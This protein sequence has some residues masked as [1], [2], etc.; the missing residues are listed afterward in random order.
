[1]LCELSFDDGCE[2]RCRSV[3]SSCHIPAQKS[4]KQ[5]QCSHHPKVCPQLLSKEWHPFLHT[6][7]CLT[8]VPPSLQWPCR[9][10]HSEVLSSSSYYPAPPRLQWAE[11][12]FCTKWWKKGRQRERGGGE[13][14]EEGEREPSFCTSSLSLGGSSQ[15]GTRGWVIR[16]Q[17]VDDQP[18]S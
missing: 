12:T 5:S 9:L 16:V 1:M 11:C 13:E 18:L 4:C 7:S 3:Q 17:T 6:G 10:S 2:L 8:H 14:R 15:G